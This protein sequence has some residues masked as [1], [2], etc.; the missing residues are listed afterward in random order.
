MKEEKQLQEIN[1]LLQKAGTEEDLYKKATMYMLA[2]F[3]AE[4]LRGA[5]FHQKMELCSLSEYYARKA[6]G[7]DVGEYKGV[8]RMILTFT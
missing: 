7:E 6:C 8:P 2:W 4:N 5:D 3:D 1:D